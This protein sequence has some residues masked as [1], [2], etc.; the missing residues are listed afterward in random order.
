M[1]ARVL[2]AAIIGIDAKPVIVEVDVAFGLRAFSIVG[3]PDSAVK[4]SKERIIS[5]LKNVG[6]KPPSQLPRRVTVNLAPANTKKQGPR[7]DVPIALG[8]L[9]ASEQLK[10]NFERTLV[11]GELA[12]D[13]RIRPVHGVLA[14][15]LMAKALGVKRA[16]LPHK[17]VAEGLLVEGM[18]I[19]GVR[20]IAD[21]LAHGRGTQPLTRAEAPETDAAK[22]TTEPDRG[23]VDL[24]HI[25]GQVLAKRA[26]EI[27]ASGN[28]NVLFHGPPG[29]GKTLLAKALP[30]I[31]PPLTREEALE[32]TR[33]YSASGEI[34]RELARVRP[35]RS[36][37]H[38]TS[39]VAVLGGGAHPLPGE[40]TLAHRGVLFLDEL[41]EFRRDVLEGL[42]QPLE[43]G[44]VH[45]TRAQGRAVFPARFLLVAAMNPCP[46]GFA[47]D[48]RVACRCSSR[49][50][51]L[52]QRRVSGPILDRFDLHVFVPR[53]AKEDLLATSE[54]EASAR[55]RARV[56]KAR[57]RQAER[58][59]KEGVYNGHL[60]GKRVQHYCVPDAEARA[61]LERAIDQYA[62]S[63]R[64]FHKV[65]KISR[66][67]AD[68][69]GS[70]VI[71]R[72]HL[73][74]AL[75]YRLPPSLK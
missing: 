24:K 46:C 43:E 13:G 51:Q 7:Y 23:V 64:A 52:Y 54:Q 61:L 60:E 48:S 38:Q 59:E 45:V 19:Y 70:D 42:R 69:A 68:L 74:E 50:V 63:A 49:E 71:T 30:G 40:M 41:P 53:L 67:I 66:T 47:G 35:F 5:A 57:Q 3:L 8:F 16:I 39:A 20:S 25:A 9:V 6:V 17:N 18:S 56:M 32:V 75:Q 4:E 10:G 27:A 65:L 2:S 11:M 31:L 1:A 34:I 44:V 28:H 72:A 29:S 33:I 12:L 55:V 36:P 73:A 37:H 15:V 58:Y 62:L 22:S 21:F 26:L 14:A